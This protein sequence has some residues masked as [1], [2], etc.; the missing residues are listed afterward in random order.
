MKTISKFICDRCKKEIEPNYGR[1][2]KG[3]I[4]M[5]TENCSMETSGLIGSSKNSEKSFNDIEE[6]A[7]CDNCF[8]KACYFEPSNY[9]P[10]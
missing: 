6:Y 4:H 7:F 3:N 1:I 10:L 5:I 8:I 9:K 2:V